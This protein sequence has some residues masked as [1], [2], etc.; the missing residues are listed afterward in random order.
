M[1]RLWHFPSSFHGLHVYSLRRFLNLLLP[2]VKTGKCHL[3]DSATRRWST[4]GRK[5]IVIHLFQLL[6]PFV[7]N[8]DQFGCVEFDST[9]T[10]FRR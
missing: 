4:N 10:A 6:N 8:V 1:V 3:V 9:P 2:N 5:F 7:S